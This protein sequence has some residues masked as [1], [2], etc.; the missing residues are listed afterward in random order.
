MEKNIT[1][2]ASNMSELVRNSFRECLFKEGEK[3]KDVVSVEG[4][5]SNFGFHPQ[6]LEEHRELLSALLANLPEEFKKG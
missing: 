5:A 2:T 1:I 4:I 3:I 6:R